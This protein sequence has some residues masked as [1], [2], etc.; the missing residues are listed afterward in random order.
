MEYYF[1]R[2][3][4]VYTYIPPIQAS[5]KPTQSLHIDEEINPNLL[6]LIEAVKEDGVIPHTGPDQ[7]GKSCLLSIIPLCSGCVNRIGS[8]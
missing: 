6:C 4:I 1:G 3:N 7:M 2:V 5:V 8:T